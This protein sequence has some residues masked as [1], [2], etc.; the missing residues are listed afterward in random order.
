MRPISLPCFPDATGRSALS[1]DPLGAGRSRP[2]WL[3]PGL[4]IGL[5]AV[6]L[7]VGRNALDTAFP[8][9][10]SLVVANR[11]TGTISFDTGDGRAIRTYAQ[12]CSTVEFDLVGH[13]WRLRS[14][15]VPAPSAGDVTFIDVQGF[16]PPFPDAGTSPAAWQ[17]VIAPDRMDYG[18][19]PPASAARTTPPCDGP[20][21]QAVHL[22]GIGTAELGSYRLSG[23]YGMTLSID[24]PGAGGCDFAASATSSNGGRDVSI[25]S[26]RAVY[27]AIHDQP[28]SMGFQPGSYDVT[29]RTSCAAW[30]VLLTPR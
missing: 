8:P 30:D 11:T 16:I 25:V 23:G 6:A 10:S 2:A 9:H 18:L 13:A 21:R 22:S 15:P 27:T 24:L 29:V 19:V 5:A 20:A 4:L 26:E 1:H 12:P 28:R 3:G 7:V 14:A 17:I